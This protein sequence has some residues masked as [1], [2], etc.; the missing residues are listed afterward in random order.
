VDNMLGKHFIAD[1][2]NG[3]DLRTGVHLDSV[4]YDVEGFRNGNLTLKSPEMNL[5]GPADGLKLLHLQ[6]HFGMDTLS[7]ARLGA[8]ATGV[9]FSP[10]AIEVAQHLS[11]ETKIH[12]DFV[13]ADVQ[14]LGDRFKHGFDIVVTTYGILCWL[15]DLYAWA[16]SIR[17]SLR[18]GGRFVL[19]EFH[20]ILDL[21]FDGK[22]SGHS[23]YF[24]TAEPVS[25][26]TTGTYADREAPISYIEHR[27]QH[28]IS[29]VISILIKV[30]LRITDMQE[31]PYASY[32]VVSALDTQKDGL[33]YSSKWPERVPFMYSIVAE[34]P[35]D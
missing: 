17:G 21:L 2:R 25:S 26:V 8:E 6:C 33:W 7:W 3:W 20:P 19:V 32:P 4:F 12:A 23:S 35:S 22:V 15:G 9:D 30:G 1:N 27:W 31:Y 11:S 13:Q 10:A 18:P 28:P 29:E 14:L 16:R 5:S 34:A 24:S